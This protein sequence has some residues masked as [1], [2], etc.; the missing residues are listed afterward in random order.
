MD[1]PDRLPPPNPEK[2]ATMRRF[3]ALPVDARRAISGAA[4]QF[5]PQAAEK[6]LARGV[7]GKR[8]GEKL[9]ASDHGNYVRTEPSR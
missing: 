9:K 4:F 3:D 1:G 7:S 5:H 8:V 6:M 2:A